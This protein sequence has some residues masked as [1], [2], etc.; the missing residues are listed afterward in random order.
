MCKVM[1]FTQQSLNIPLSCVFPQ[2]HQKSSRQ[3]RLENV[4]G[5]CLT[6]QLNND[7][8]WIYTSHDTLLGPC[9]TAP[10]LDSVQIVLVGVFTDPLCFYELVKSGLYLFFKI[11]FKHSGMFSTSLFQIGSNILDQWKPL[12]VLL[13]VLLNLHCD[14]LIFV[15]FEIRTLHI[16]IV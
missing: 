16:V 3:G 14:V 4:D 13:S 5:E 8:F 6:P 9:Y 15:V 11:L 1:L 12:V 10:C 2:S 7:S